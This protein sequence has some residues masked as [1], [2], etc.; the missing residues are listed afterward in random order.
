MNALC[1]WS[2][3]KSLRWGR[4]KDHFGSKHPVVL[5]P[6]TQLWDVPTLLFHVVG[7]KYWYNTSKTSKFK[8]PYNANILLW[9]I[10]LPIIL[11]CPCWLSCLGCTYICL[12]YR[13]Q[14]N[15]LGFADRPV[16]LSVYNIFVQNHTVCLP[17]FHNRV[18]FF[19]IRN[20]DIFQWLVSGNN[21]FQERIQRS[22]P[23]L[24]RYKITSA[25][26]LAW[27]YIITITGFHLSVWLKNPVSFEYSRH[28]FPLYRLSALEQARDADLLSYMQMH[29]PITF[30]EIEK[31]LQLSWVR[32][33]YML[34]TY[35]LWRPYEETFS[36]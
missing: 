21:Y 31:H 36:F 7:R 32:T 5:S 18:E 25:N 27:N 28:I 19:I 26:T 10:I 20:T 12:Y 8:L 2:D 33:G 29:L 14:L 3:T 1:F 11:H 16:R 35:K 4:R 6:W 17:H 22:E 9:L 34:C 15:S 13:L 23:A 24:N 30:T